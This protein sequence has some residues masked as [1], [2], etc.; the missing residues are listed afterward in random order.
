MSN[1]ISILRKNNNWT[2]KE[3]AKKLNITT[4]Y[5]GM[6]ETGVRTPSLDIAYKIAKLFNTSIEKIF[7]V[8]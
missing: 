5:L 1:K 4:S 7:F 8:N 6:I 3:V 2:Q